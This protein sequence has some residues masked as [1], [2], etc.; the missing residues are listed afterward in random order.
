MVVLASADASASSPCRDGLH[1]PGWRQRDGGT[2]RVGLGDRHPDRH[3]LR[4]PGRGSDHHQE[5]GQCHPASR[6]FSGWPGQTFTQRFPEPGRYPIV[7][8][9]DPLESV[10]VTVEG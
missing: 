2:T 3:S 4:L 7:C 8:T 6:T 10:V 9:V 5:P 1:H